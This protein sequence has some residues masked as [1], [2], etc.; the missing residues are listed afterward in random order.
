MGVEDGRALR[1]R[2]V[3]LALVLVAVRAPVAL[4]IALQASLVPRGRRLWAQRGVVVRGV[5]A[6]VARVGGGGGVRAGGARGRGGFVF[7]S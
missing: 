5:D 4:G 2:V 3:V 6:T 7:H 1:L